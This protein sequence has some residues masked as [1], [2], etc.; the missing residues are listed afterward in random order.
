[1]QSYT[2]IFDKNNIALKVKQNSDEQN[3]MEPICNKEKKQRMIFPFIKQKNLTF[4]A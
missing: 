3:K 1:M 4:S 2:F